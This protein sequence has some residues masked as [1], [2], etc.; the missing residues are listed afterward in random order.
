M[1][2]SSSS[3]PS[4]ARAETPRPEIGPALKRDRLLQRVRSA[5]KRLSP[6]PSSSTLKLR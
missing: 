2:P 6:A 1:T 4:P 3:D 5:R